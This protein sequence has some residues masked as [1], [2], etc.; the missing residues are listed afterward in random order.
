MSF[1]LKKYIKDEQNKARIAKKQDE[2]TAVAQTGHR[3]NGFDLKQ[4]ITGEQKK[5][6][7]LTNLANVRNLVDNF[8]GILYDAVSS[9]PIEPDIKFTNY[10]PGK[11]DYSREE[12][13]WQRELDHSLPEFGSYEYFVRREKQLRPIV[14]EMGAN[15]M[16]YDETYMPWVREYGEYVEGKRDSWSRQ[17]DAADV[18]VVKEMY[19]R[20]K[21]ED[22]ILDEYNQ[23]TAIVDKFDKK[24]VHYDS[25][26]D[27]DTKSGWEEASYAAERKNNVADALS[28]TRL[29]KDKPTGLYDPV[30]KEKQA[31]YDNINHISDLA[32]VE[33]AKADAYKYYEENKDNSYENDVFGI[34]SGNY[35]VGR[36]GIK[37]NDA[38]YASFQ[39]GVD[40]LEAV[41]VYQLL[42]NRI[43]NN[44]AE[45]FKEGGSLK[46]WWA[47]IAQYAP[48][49][50]DQA[51][52]SLTG[53]AMALPLALVSKTAYKK[54]GND[55]AAAINAEYMFRQTAGSA[56]I[57]QLQENGLS[58]EDAKKLAQDEALASASVELVLSWAAGKVF[59][60]AGG[61]NAV[62]KP[63]AKV[64]GA[65]TNELRRIGIS[66]AGANTV[67]KSIKG[68]GKFVL[69]NLGEAAEEGTQEGISIVA[70]RYARSGEESSATKMLLNAFDLS[71]YSK[72]DWK[73]IG[74]AAEAGFVVGSFSNAIHA[75]ANN[76]GNA[77]AGVGNFV[78]DK[79]NKKRAESVSE[80]TTN[81]EKPSQQTRDVQ[82]P[83]SDV[84]NVSADDGS[85]DKLIQIAETVK[86]NDFT[87]SGAD[88]RSLR[89]KVIND[90]FNR[91]VMEK[92]GSDIASVTPARN[93]TAED[94]SV[95]HVAQFAKTVD[96]AGATVLTE[97]YS[98]DTDPISYI[99][100][101]MKVYG[102]GRKG[103]DI[104]TVEG[105]E[106]IN[107]AQVKAMYTAGVADSGRDGGVI[108]TAGEIAYTEN[109]K[110]SGF[111]GANN[112]VYFTVPDSDVPIA[113]SNIATRNNIVSVL[114]NKPDLTLSEIATEFAPTSKE[115]R[116]LQAYIDAG[117]GN[118]IAGTVIKSSNYRTTHDERGGVLAYK[119]GGSY[120]LNARLRAKAELSTEQ[121]TIVKSFDAALESLPD[122]EGTV[123]RNLG[124]DEFGGKDVF[125]AFV[126]EHVVGEV[127]T[128]PAYTSS[129]KSVDGYPVDNEYS[130]HIVIHGKKGKDISVGYG[131]ESE[132]EVTFA[133]NT[134]FYVAS[135]E[136][137][138][139]T[140]NIVLEEVVYEHRGNQGVHK[141][142]SG[143]GEARKSSL[144]DRTSEVQQVHKEDK[145]DV[146]VVP[147]RDTEEN[148]GRR[149]ELSGVRG[150]ITEGNIYG[151]EVR[152]RNGGEWI[153]GT[154]TGRP[155]QGLEESS[156]RNPSRQETSRPADG[157]ATSLTYGEKVSTA[158]LGIGGGTNA[159]TIRLVKGGNT[160]AIAEAKTIAKKRGL[161]LVLFAGENLDIRRDGEQISARAY[162]S[163]DRVFVRVDHPTFTAAQL[164]KH[165][166]GHDM[167]RKGEIDPNKTRARL[168]KTYGYVSNL[169]A[170]AYASN[171]YNMTAEEI[172]EE[173]ICDS[174]A[175]M[176][177]F[178]KT[179][180][181]VSTK[182]TL[183]AIKV[184]VAENKTPATRGPPIGVGAEGKA[185][186]D[187]RRYS[188]EYV[189]WA[190]DDGII[191][192]E[193]RIKFF[194]I[195]ANINKLGEKVRRTSYGGYIVDIG[196]KLLFTDGNWH[197][198]TLSSVIVLN[199][200]S[201][202]SMEQA[203]DVIF[204]GKHTEAGYEQSRQIIEDAYWT[205][206]IE[207]YTQRDSSSYA[208]KDAGRERTDSRRSYKEARSKINDKASREL[209]IEAPNATD[210]GKASRDLIG[211]TFP[212]Y[213]ISQSDA[214]EWATRWAHRDDIKTG[215]QT[216]VFYRGSPY[217]I[218]KYDS[219]ELGYQIEKKIRQKEY[220]EFKE[221]KNDELGKARSVKEIANEIDLVNFKGNSYDGRKR[222]SIVAQ[223]EHRGE[224]NQVQRV[225]KNEARRGQTNGDRSGD[226]SSRREDS[227]RNRVVKKVPKPRASLELDT[228]EIADEE[229]DFLETVQSSIRDTVR[230]E[231]DRMGQEYG[232]IPKG[233]NPARE[234]NI[235]KKT[236]KDKYV[237]QTVRT[238]LEAKATPEE[239]LPSIE[240]LVADGEFSYDRY[241]DKTAVADA[242]NTIRNKGWVKTLA[243]WF[244]DS[245]KGKISKE[246]TALGWAL[247]NNAVNKGDVETA[248]DVLDHIV[249]NQRNAAQALQATRILKQLSPESQ[250][251]QV[252]RSVANLQEELNEKYGDEKSPE[253]KIDEELAAEFL[254]AE[255]Q[256]ARDAVLKDIYRDIG[257]QLPSRLADR[258]RAWRYLAMLGNPR[259]HIRNIVGNAGFA[260]VVALKNLTATAIESAV[261]RVSGGKI[262]RT[263]AFVG[264]SESDRDLLKAAWEDYANVADRVSNGGKYNDSAVANKAIEDGRRVFKSKLLEGGRKGNSKL[265]EVEDVW[266]AKPHYAYALAQYCKANNITADQLRKGK[267]LGAARDYAIKEAQ[268][269]TYKDTNMV[270]QFVSELG[271]NGN[272]KNEVRKAAGVA[273][274]AILPFRKTPANILVRGG[275]YSP[276][277]LLKSLSYDLVQVAKGQKSSAEVI[278]SISAGLTGTGLLALGVWLAAEGLVRG[279]GE[280]DEEKEFEE[281]MGH[282]AYSLEL[283]DGTSVTLDWLAPECLPFFV[284]VNLWEMTKKEDE[285][286]TLTSLISAFG[287]AT[288][289]MLEMSCLQGVND[290]VESVGYASADD[291][292]GLLSILINAATSYLIQG[293]PT[294]LGQL[295]RTGEDERNTTFTKKDA[296]VPVDMQRFI[297]NVSAKIPGWDFQQIPYIDAWGRSEQ[298][299]GAGVRAFNNFINPSYTSNI[300]ESEME[301]ELLRLYEVTGE[302]SV[303]P[304]RANKYFTVN[305]ETK[306]LTED[307]YIQYAT[308]K[309]QT[310]YRLVTAITESKQYQ[311]LDDAEKIDAIAFAYDYSNQVAKKAV[312]AYTPEKWVGNMET[313]KKTYGIPE[314]TFILLKTQT[315]DIESLKYI[316]KKGELD[317]IDNSKGL[318]IM[319]VIY[320]CP[321]LKDSQ[322]KKLFEYFDVGKKVRH[323]N[324]ALVNEKL[325]DMRK[326]AK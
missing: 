169:Y 207:R 163:G 288:E 49:G 161:R 223:T 266:F 295:E 188:G 28:N 235:P 154:D 227:R 50:I 165:E 132:Q 219:A 238:I 287:T 67:V 166:A 111:T 247:Y 23:V 81:I 117:Y 150:E 114:Q 113:V 285:P 62:K 82:A 19:D 215:D 33:E 321:G 96:K 236:A 181:E 190:V 95:Q 254:K 311:N 130:A 98:T 35:R 57:R 261:H 149:A 276:L 102:A 138:G 48:Q 76:I 308:K 168:E 119:G 51:V 145:V 77:V 198:P 191:T 278:D 172:W 267:A 304:S 46:N 121:L 30:D 316:N 313:A 41:E 280:D 214:N 134:K 148:T 197:A 160:A 206:Y 85:I 100:D 153:D 183:G 290:L 89:N 133:R 55:L 136:N 224:N 71:K 221:L 18:A 128:Y 152:L 73:Q 184:D 220:N 83:L 226:L 107:P 294:L 31:E 110:D 10:V 99:S 217:L 47:S 192:E 79:V 182:E 156:R 245:K 94:A 118:E 185:S 173:V 26:G 201:E 125:D 88:A 243:N 159:K 11:H 176:N 135:L 68:A 233:E 189:A 177:V 196:K 301:K 208:R 272:H 39:A 38:G 155:I 108:D 293:I 15:T 167:I 9:G 175:D 234:V 32:D 249:G 314:S 8:G 1:D 204:N 216:I 279:H 291:R 112:E 124:F 84:R 142:D 263:K 171:G 127:I 213:N 45:T 141:R 116:V 137:D 69:S 299:G 92:D 2:Y 86:E 151:E 20:I 105:V 270:S 255:T 237:S 320:D 303:L 194:H 122:Y 210:Q 302:G 37:T 43:Q 59:Q 202:T 195:I 147:G 317:T 87:N 268:K 103:A 307:E 228:H 239:M 123:Y 129:S 54:A 246:H 24:G 251:Y 244:S 277:G 170:E 274:E 265:L 21:Y 6:R 179:R 17:H 109:S 44:N 225:D 34:W 309:G 64:S 231:L 25:K 262:S 325:S 74:D 90:E 4:Y 240:E 232:W 209:D 61:S 16:R 298:T 305:G 241:T 326:Q 7:A 42:T 36:T 212:P 252:Q 297:G 264:I 3:K 306:R 139:K 162:I 257:R 63:L 14:E 292:S 296:F 242:E 211:K 323:Y 140:A 193:E 60:K 65:L 80:K 75:G 310:A 143:R 282:Q 158:S 13:E 275:E 319:K 91:W 104:S 324:K 70:D 318:Q 300:E 286:I 250:L 5:N 78:V 93:N 281:L 40:D 186:R 164:I 229:N 260:P 126:A 72:E 12:Y 312:S 203:K 22:E 115:Y 256:E 56:F 53:Y 205:G 315:G 106:S 101:M 248:I 284:G 258:W 97:M 259:T 218:E 273:I 289:P 230:E 52:N 157:E 199:D 131:I 271:R 144:G 66:E 178:D 253:L 200:F 283:P 120:N 29:V 269:A 322:R 174:L 187:T 222:V 27:V 58:V 180:N 146:R